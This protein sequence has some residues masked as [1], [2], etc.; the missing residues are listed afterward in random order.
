M[1]IYAL[2]ASPRKG[3][4]SDEMLE[5][6]INGVKETNP[7]IEIEKVN[8]YDL[9][10]KGCRGCYACQLKVTE[11]G[12]CL[13]RD[14]AY[15]LLRGIKSSDGLVF[16][17]PVYYFDVPSQMRAILE[18]LFYPGGSEREIPVATI[19]TMNQKPEK[20]EKYFKQHLDDIAF[21]FRNQFK[22][23][24]EQLYIYNTLHWKNPEKYKFTMDSYMDKTK[25]RELNNSANRQSCHDAGVRF[26]KRV[27]Q[28]AI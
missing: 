9:D 3:W 5:S 21:F 26:A 19:Y 23:E 22:T 16:A 10:Y 4:N 25:N 28:K 6:F 1:K 20:M 13:F 12:Q 7:D 8:I 27:S 17:A 18:R 11:D 2:N 15:D 14:G 24:P